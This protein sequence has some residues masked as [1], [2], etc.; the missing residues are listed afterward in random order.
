MG[1]RNNA[2]GVNP[3]KEKVNVVAVADQNQDVKI[4]VIDA[5][6]AAEAYTPEVKSSPRIN[7][8]KISRQ[9]RDC[10]VS[11]KTTQVLLLELLK[12]IGVGDMN[13]PW[14]QIQSYQSDGKSM[15]E[16]AKSLFYV[17]SEL[18]RT[19]DAR[20]G[21]GLINNMWEDSNNFFRPFEA[22]EKHYSDQ[23]AGLIGSVEDGVVKGNST[24][25]I[26]TPNA[27]GLNKN[28][29]ELINIGE[30]GLPEEKEEFVFEIRPQKS[31]TRNPNID[32][33]KKA[34]EKL[35]FTTARFYSDKLLGE[36]DGMSATE[37]QNKYNYSLVEYD[38][39]IKELELHNY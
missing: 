36:H 2:F 5:I 31:N 13:G 7:D 39:I 6:S 17:Y 11:G 23:R 19:Y 22:Q 15:T 8:E 14:R 10:I 16:V 38:S 20:Y 9:W 28:G 26:T 34:Y 3:K 27:K 30:I 21:V 4:A 33:M 1:I 35:S 29:V 18:S 12:D 24:I 25:I 32:L 37:I